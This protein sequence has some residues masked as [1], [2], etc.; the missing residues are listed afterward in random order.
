MGRPRKSKEIL[1][2]KRLK[3]KYQGLP[4]TKIAKIVGVHHSTL[5]ASSWYQTIKPVQGYVGAS[6][7]EQVE[8]DRKS[9]KWPTSSRVKIP[10]SD[11]SMEAKRRTLKSARPAVNR[12]SQEVGEILDLL[13]LVTK[14]QARLV[15]KLEGLYEQF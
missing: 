3:A 14:V 1:Q 11:S 12:P 6:R 8:A 4:I 15:V 13:R 2:A 5:Y 7:Q 10:S 9:F